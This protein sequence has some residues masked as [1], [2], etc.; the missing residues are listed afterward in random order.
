M[1]SPDDQYK[2]LGLPPGA[3]NK[4]L[5]EIEREKQLAAQQAA[6]RA[7]EPAPPAE[8]RSPATPARVP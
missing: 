7:A 1:S 2:T 3:R 5:R 4:M 6:G 8:P